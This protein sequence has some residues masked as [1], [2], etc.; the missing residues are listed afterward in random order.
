MRKTT[1]QG[2]RALFAEAECRAIAARYDGRSETIDAL[3]REYAARGVKRHNIINAARR[4]GYQ[5]ARVRKDWSAKEDEWIRENS[6]SY[7]HLTLPTN[8][9]V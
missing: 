8:R 5:T 4:G 2:N 3:L 7:T 1:R 9:E 6:V